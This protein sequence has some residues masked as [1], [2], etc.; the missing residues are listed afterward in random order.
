M[1]PTSLVLVYLAMKMSP[2]TRPTTAQVEKNVMIVLIFCTS[3]NVIVDINECVRTPELCQ[4]NSNCVNVDGHYN[5]ICDNGY[6]E[7]ASFC[8]QLK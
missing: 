3:V 6:Y 7:N 2:Q 8:C 1:A 5:C 4:Q